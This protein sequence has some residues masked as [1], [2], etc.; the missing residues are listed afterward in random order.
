MSTRWSP[1]SSQKRPTLRAPASLCLVCWAVQTVQSPN[2][3]SQRRLFT[4]LALL[5]GT[6][7]KDLGTGNHAPPPRASV[8]ASTPPRPSR[9]VTQVG[10]DCEGGGRQGRQESTLA[11]PHKPPGRPRAG[12]GGEGTPHFAPQDSWGAREPAAKTQGQAYAPPLPGECGLLRL[13]SRVG[14]G[15]TTQP[16][17][18]PDTV[19]P[20]CLVGTSLELQRA[21]HWGRSR[22]ARPTCG[23]RPTQSSVW[24]CRSALRHSLPRKKVF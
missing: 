23:R 24:P 6:P 14:G 2:S 22:A 11:H 20:S 13:N 17:V 10:P 18:S 15:Q 19:P 3:V 7:G 9:E 5:R 16:W 12:S 4:P 21:P 8:C 1:A